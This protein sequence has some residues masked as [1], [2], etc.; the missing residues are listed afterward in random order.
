MSMRRWVWSK[1]QTAVRGKAGQVAMYLACFVSLDGGLG[2]MWAKMG[3]PVYLA[4]IETLVLNVALWE[5]LS[6]PGR[7]AKRRSMDDEKPEGS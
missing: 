1:T 3:T 2:V 5:L 7:R 6:T 4:V